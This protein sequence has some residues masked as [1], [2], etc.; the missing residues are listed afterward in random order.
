[1]TPPVVSEPFCLSE[2][3][4]TRA[5][6]Y[7]F[8]NKSVRIGDIT[9]AVWLDGVSSVMARSFDHRTQRWSSATHVDDGRDNHACPSLTAA[10]DGRL[11]V[12]YGPIELGTLQAGQWREIGPRELE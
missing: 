12:A 9:H 1:M 11:R 8:A 7:S 4:S 2:N 5:T 10:P 3:A 6:A